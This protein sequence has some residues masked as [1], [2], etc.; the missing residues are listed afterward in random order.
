VEQPILLPNGSWILSVTPVKGWGDP[1]GLSLNAAFGLLFSL[2]LAW[3][4][5]LLI[6]SKDHKAGLEVLVAK[7]TAEIRQSE[8]RLRL[9]VEHAPA[10]LA[11]F[12]RNMR[13]VQVSRRWLNDY[14]LGEDLQGLSHYDVFPEIPDSWKVAHRRGLAGEV[15]RADA[16]RFAR[17]DGSVQWLRWEVR[18]WRDAEGEVGGIVIFTEDISERKRVEEELKKSEAKFR[19]LSQEFNGLLD[20]IPDSLMLLDRDLKV[21][22]SNRAAAENLGIAGAELGGCHCYTLWYERTTPCEPCPVMQSFTS[23]TS[24]NETVIRPDGRV[25]D[26]RTVPL[27]DEQGQVAKVIELKRDIT[28]H[29]QLETQYLHAQKMESI[30]TLAGGVAHDFNNILT[31]IVGLGQITLMKMADC[32]PYRGNIGGILEAAERATHLTK[33]LLL[34]SRKQKSERRPV[35]LNNIINKTEKFLHRIIGEDIA[36]K[37]EPHS[38]PLPV[39]ADSPQLE[40]VLMNLAVNARDAMP[41]GGELILRSTETV[42]NKEFVA[43]HGY[44]PPGPYALLSISDTGTGMDKATQQ[45]IFEPFFSTKEVGKGTGLGLAVVYGIIKQHDG[46]ITVYSAP[47]Q[48]STFQI[49]LPLTTVARQEMGTQQAQPVVG[50]TETILLAEDNDQVRELVTSVLTEAGYTVIVA[51]DGAEAICKFKENSDAIHLLLFDL[52]MPK[53]N[54]KV[55]A[56][57]IHKIRP[58]MKTIFASGYSPDIAQQK[59]SLNEGSHLV[60]KPVSPR[61]LLKKVRDVLDGVQS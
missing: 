50:G 60:Y 40:Q 37:Q 43:A 21:L 4:T 36:L 20:A 44:G 30:G 8:E 17:A 33:E 28:E 7:R 19:N 47:G 18:P 46:F 56:D 58:E 22:W 10:S 9:F 53:M 29:R 6:E 24:R 57:E 32:D 13:Y 2:L 31:V 48:G 38:S 61:D 15:V 1:I 55:A 39:L 42:L 51:V 5:K 14:G 26:I 34:F 59:A 23:A 16:D 54:G 52:I 27:M 25:W 12:D 35:D 41:Q 3:L 49:Y 45:R 11:M